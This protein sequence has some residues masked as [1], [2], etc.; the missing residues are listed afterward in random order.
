MNILGIIPARY[1]ST[2]LPGKP[3]MTIGGKTIIRRVYEQ[4][5][6][7]LSLDKVVVA[8]DDQRILDEVKSFGGEAIMTSSRHRNGTERC[9]E[10]IQRY[11]AN[12]VINIQG[13]EPFIAPEQIDLLA[14]I[15]TQETELGTLVRKVDNLESLDDPARMKV[16][17]DAQF[18]AIYFSRQAVPFIRDYPKHEWLQHHVFY[19]HVCIYSYRTDVLQQ[20]VKL[21]PTPLEVAESLEQLRWIENGYQIKLAETE[22]DAIGIDTPADL[23]KARK[24]IEK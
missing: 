11:E 4:A 3:L 16:L 21:S 23:E 24:Q 12:F 14:G 5:S 22:L 8:T 7:C 15:M 9:A 17:V 10:V 20:I 6:R 19:Q 13:D 2:R 1:G 18:N